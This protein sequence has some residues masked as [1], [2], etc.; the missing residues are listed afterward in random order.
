MDPSLK[1]KTIAAALNVY[2]IS[3]KSGRM[4][5][6]VL[7]EVCPSQ[8]TVKRAKRR[9]VMKP[10]I[11]ILGVLSPTEAG[12][13]AMLDAQVRDDSCV[14]SAS[15]DEI[16]LGR[17]LAARQMANPQTGTADVV[18]LGVKD[19]LSVEQVKARGGSPGN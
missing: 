6:I 14:L 13:F 19:P 5:H 7:D 9:E 1:A 18:V 10:E 2:L 12:I 4:L 11:S 8:S 15:M 3:P 17:G 16:V